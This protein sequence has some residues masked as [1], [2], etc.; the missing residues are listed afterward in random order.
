MNSFFAKNVQLQPTGTEFKK[1]YKLRLTVWSLMN[2][3]KSIGILPF[4]CK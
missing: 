3:R 4:N 1:I 2:D